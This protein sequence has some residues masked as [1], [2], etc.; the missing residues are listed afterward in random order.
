[1]GGAPLPLFLCSR[2]FNKPTSLKRLK[3]VVF[4]VK[5]FFTRGIHICKLQKIQRKQKSVYLL[6]G[7]NIVL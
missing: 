6:W 5:P 4:D 7:R 2:W 3:C 1:M